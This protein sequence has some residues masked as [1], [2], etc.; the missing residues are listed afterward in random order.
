MKPKLVL[1]K[2]QQNGQI[3]ITLSKKETERFQINKIIIERGDITV[4]LTEIQRIMRAYYEQLYANK[5]DDLD[6]SVQFL[7]RH[8]LKLTQGAIENM[9]G[10]TKIYEI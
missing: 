7:G 9:N 3:L 1:W 2:D 4:K 8:S 6:K 5:L 10:S